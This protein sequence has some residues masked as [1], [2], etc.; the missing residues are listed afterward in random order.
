MLLPAEVRSLLFHEDSN[1]RWFALDYLCDAHDPAQLTAADVWAGADRYRDLDRLAFIRHLPELASTPASSARVF[2]GLRS[3]RDGRFFSHLCGVLLRL[4]VDEVRRAMGDPRI[5]RRLPSVARAEV[6]EVLHFAG[7]S[8]DELWGEVESCAVEIKYGRFLM[9]PSLSR[10]NHLAQALARFP[11]RAAARALDAL[12]DAS[13]DERGRWVS[14]FSTR[15]F[16]NVRHPGALVP[17]LNLAGDE[18]APFFLV[19]EWAVDALVYLGTREL[20]AA[21]AAGFPG[22]GEWSCWH[23]AHVLGRIKRPESEQVLVRLLDATSDVP[24]CTQLGMALCELGTTSPEALDRLRA[25]VSCEH[26]DPHRG[27]LD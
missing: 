11:E 6:A 4:P 3:E 7:Q 24:G 17:L 15:L 9:T 22:S 1:V 5:A 8:F 10:V 19:G 14:A 26:F 13:E 21:I 27:A 25:L 20:V 23:A 16:R 12:L 18:S 2:E